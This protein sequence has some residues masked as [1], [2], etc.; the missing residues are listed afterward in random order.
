MEGIESRKFILH[1][2]IPLL[3]DLSA[4][5]HQF[6]PRLIHKYNNVKLRFSIIDTKQQDFKEHRNDSHSKNSIKGAAKT[7]PCNNYIRK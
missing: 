7:T 6:I 5:T 1:K 2:T 3:P 4:F